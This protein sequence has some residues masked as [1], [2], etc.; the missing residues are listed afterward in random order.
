MR[1]LSRLQDS[2]PPNIT[3]ESP[4]LIAEDH[5]LIYITDGYGNARVLV[6]GANGKR[7][8]QWGVRGTLPGQFDLPHA[9][10]VGPDGTVYVADRENDRIEKFGLDGTYTGQIAHLGRVYGIKLVA[11]I[12]WASLGPPDQPPGSPGGWIVKLDAKT[13]QV[14]GHLDIAEGAAGHS[15][16]VTSSGEPVITLGNGLLW[17]HTD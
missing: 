14:L 4:P 3:E 11:G 5:S 6:Y 12:L 2:C 1:Q 16:D 7:I 15:I 9:I 13:G 17:F 8:K 10:Q